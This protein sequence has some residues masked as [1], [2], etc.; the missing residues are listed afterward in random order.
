[1]STCPAKFQLTLGCTTE[2]NMQTPLSMFFM[3]Y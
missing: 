3:H 2:V 1:L